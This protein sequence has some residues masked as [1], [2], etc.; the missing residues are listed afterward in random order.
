MDKKPKE[1]ISD[2]VRLRRYFFAGLATLFPLVIT[3]YAVT[4]LFRFSD[5][6]FGRYANAF[7]QANYGFMI[8]GLG[9][10]FGFLVIVI[11]GMLSMQVIGKVIWPFFEFIF[12][13]I[14]FVKN[15]YQPAQQFSG[16]I[17]TEDSAKKFAKVVLVEYPI[18]GCW[19]VGFVTNENLPEFNKKSGLELVS[20]LVPT[21][22]SPLTGYLVI[23]PRSKV[24][25]INMSF[26]EA[27][28]FIMSSGVVYSCNKKPE[29][30]KDI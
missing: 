25:E 29:I 9:L 28:G 30:A 20:V 19:G 16:M 23:V 12:S 10:I 2:L 4:L 5:R 22:P 17:F 1:K 14:P 11:I 26:E 8:P 7:L 21:P 18:G 15:I 13:K 27:I 3:I 24:K 6:L